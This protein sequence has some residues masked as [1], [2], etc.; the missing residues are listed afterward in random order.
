MTT[1][2]QA[3]DDGA[4][5][6]SPAPSSAVARMD[7]TW[8]RDVKWWDAAFYVVMAL[9]LMLLLRSGLDERARWL[10]SAVV[11]AIVV[12]YTTLGRR[13]ARTREQGRALAY[14][15]VL[16]TGTVAMIVMTDAG[17]FL[18][19]VAFTQTWML[20][21]RRA[22][23]VVLCVLLTVASTLAL[24]WQDGGVDRARL[25]GSAPTMGVTL[26]FSLGLGLWVAHTLRQSERYA[27]LLDD[28]HATQAELARSHHAA[29]VSAERE[30]LARE[31]HDTLAQGFTSVVMLAQS[32][33]ADLARGDD[34]ATARA[35]DRLAVIEST[36]RD[37]LAEARSLVAAFAPAP[38][39]AGGLGEA[40]VRTTRRFT[41]ETGIPVEDDVAALH[42][43]RE[44]EVVLLRAAQ[45]ALANVR[46]H[47]GA[48]RVRLAL[49]VA[50][51]RVTLRVTDDGV[52]IPADVAEGF[53]LRGM[54]E[55]VAAGGGD[56]R[57]ARPASGGTE[58]LV[59][60]P[61]PSEARP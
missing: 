24:A 30:R 9:N 16:L 53:G 60:L 43:D 33:R 19:F 49:A 27:H 21:E 37:N 22:V 44:S 12:A 31:I 25:V 47:A 3:T 11:G 17:T 20:T 54:R 50:D 14:L 36:A 15:A 57:V 46:K 58:L 28:L 8:A 18:L 48:R 59:W 55:R 10:A 34:D 1:A 41:A 32:A 26:V 35:V 42:L 2:E 61:L 6:V 51:G 45:E 23:G 38:L 39:Q 29:G 7:H 4:A 40:L 52:G 13:A 56:V 5:A